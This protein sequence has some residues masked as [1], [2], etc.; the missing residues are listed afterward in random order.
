MA[1]W[2]LGAIPLPE[3]SG[4]LEKLIVPQVVKIFLLS[5][6]GTRMFCT[7]STR[8]PR[9]SLAWTRRIHSKLLV[10]MHFKIILPYTPVWYKWSPSFRFP[11]QNSVFISFLSLRA[12]CP[13]LLILRY[14]ITWYSESEIVMPKFWCFIHTHIYIYICVC[15]CVYIYIYIYIYI[16]LLGILFMYGIV[17]PWKGSLYKWW[18]R[19]WTQ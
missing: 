6:Y 12:T 15:V 1:Y 13:A 9:L 14:C 7:V 5:L 10:E 2:L 4:L 11:Y 19:L 3:L 8:A 16:L 17:K 18:K